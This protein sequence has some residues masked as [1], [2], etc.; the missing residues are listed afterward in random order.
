ME[1]LI[2][3]LNATVPVFAMYTPPQKTDYTLFAALR[4]RELCET[5][6]RQLGLHRIVY[7]HMHS[8][9]CS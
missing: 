2:F 1:N 7:I 5:F 3:R 4:R 8:A 9:L 6:C